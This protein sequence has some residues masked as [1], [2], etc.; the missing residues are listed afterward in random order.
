MRK[1]NW[2][3]IIIFLV[4]LIIGIGMIAAGYFCLLWE[5]PFFIS[6][7]CTLLLSVL[8]FCIICMAVSSLKE[9][10]RENKED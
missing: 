2:L 6:I 10:I 9:I 3:N 4:F 7:I 1:M 8:G 5:L